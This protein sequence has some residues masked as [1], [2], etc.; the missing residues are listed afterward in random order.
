MKKS[1]ALLLCAVLAGAAGCK[2]SQPTAPPVATPTV[3]LSKDKAPV[4]SPL[5]LTYKFEVA[6]DARFDA[7]YTVFLHVMEP[8]GEKMWQD[9]HS[10]EVPTTQWKPGQTIEYTRTIFVPNYPYIG[11]GNILIG[12]YN[13]ATGTRLPL[14]AEEVS[15]RAYRAGRLTI[16][17]SAENL[18]LLYND[19]WHPTEV[20]PNNPAV[21]WQWTKKAATISF[22][23]P[24][25][26]ATL[27][28]EFDARTDLFN[29]PQQVTLTVAGKP[30]ATFAADSRD[31]TLRTFEVKADQFGSEDMAQIS[32][33]VDRT[34]AGA[35]GD[36]RQLG[37]R[38]FHAFVE[39]K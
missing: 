39:Q 16:Q 1:A 13:P 27:Y 18:F 29:P 38:V 37:I 23:N 24:R 20:D 31:R 17:P 15:N 9:D 6:Q 33:E 36:P 32:I 28:L 35:A 7:D 26:D 30:L 34:F 19:G 10:P 4:G 5:R 21:E 12:L 11:E 8:D 3:T 22:R 2:R 14:N 25:R